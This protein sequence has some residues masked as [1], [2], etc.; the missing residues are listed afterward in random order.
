MLVSGHLNP[1]PLA[2]AF[3]FEADRA[4]TYATV[5]GPALNDGRLVISDRGPFGTAAYQGFG[6]GIDRD[7]IAAMSTA[8][9]RGRKSDIVIVIDIDPV[10]GLQRKSRSPERDRFDEEN[11]RFQQRV[12]EGFLDAARRFGPGAYVVDGQQA[13]EAV[14]RQVLDLV[15]N[16]LRRRTAAT[17]EMHTPP[18]N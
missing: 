3:L 6:R 1:S 17:A 18:S 8:A 16:G 12:R 10:V 7:L 4:E 11:L 2:E 13:Q 5:I 14:L 15:R 9:C